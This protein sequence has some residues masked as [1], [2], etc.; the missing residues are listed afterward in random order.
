M[1]EHGDVEQGVQEA[2]P[3]YGDTGAPALAQ[4][5]GGAVRAVPLENATAEPDE[6]TAVLG[7]DVDEILPGRAGYGA[8]D[9]SEEEQKGAKKARK[10]VSDA[11][12]T[13]MA[14]ERTFF[15]WLWTGLHIGAIGSFIFIAFDGDR[16][17]PMRLVVVGLSWVVAL[18][19]VFYGTFAYYRR[20]KAL[21]SGDLSVVP[22]FTREH[23]PL[24]VLTAL[25]I[26]IGSAL[27]YAARSDF[28]ANGEAAAAAATAAVGG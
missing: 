27:G 14:A 19:L 20:R 24:V 18:A 12:K 9:A 2:I 11:L 1:G 26:V 28:K 10:A 21:R 16:Q 8:T 4:A 3:Q 5:G 22:M 6:L 17:D 13:D 23:T 25:F 7:T 15:K